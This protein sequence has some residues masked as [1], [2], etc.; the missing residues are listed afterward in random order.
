MKKTYI[1]D[2]DTDTLSRGV[3]FMDEK[4][5]L[6]TKGVWELCTTA[7]RGFKVILNDHVIFDSKWKVIK[8]Y[9]TD[10]LLTIECWY[11]TILIQ[12]T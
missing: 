12:K 1:F 10:T 5:F 2:S 7:N 8:V 11:K 3:Y 4:E 9:D 6:P